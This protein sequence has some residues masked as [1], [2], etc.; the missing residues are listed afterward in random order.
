MNAPVLRVVILAAGQGKRMQSTRPKV[1]HRLAGQPLLAYVLANAAALQA[2]HIQIVHGHA[3]E[4]VR[5][6]FAD[7]AVD[8]VQ[9]Q[10]PRGT[11]DAVRLALAAPV[12]S[13]EEVTLILYGDVPLLQPGTLQKLVDEARNGAIGLLTQTRETP[14]GYGRIV[15]N[16]QGSVLGIVEHKDASTEQRA[17]REI[18][19][20]ILAASS[21]RLRQWV[22]ALDSNNAQGEFYLT[23]IVGLAVRDGVPVHTHLPQH[24][25]EADGIND[26]A[27]LAAL[28]RCYQRF[29]ADAL[30]AKGTRLADP[31]RVDVRG[32]LLCEADVEID[33]GC[34]FEGEV[35]L[36]AG[37]VVE[38]YCVLRNT[39]V[40]AGSHIRAFSHLDGA[41][42]ADRCVIGPY[43][44]LRP[45]AELDDE[46]HIGNF[47]E[48]KASHI[49]PRSKANHL[50]YVGDASVGSGVNIGAGT[51]T[52]NFDGANKHRTV[53]GD[54]AF[55]GSASQLVAP[56]TVGAGATIG[57]GTTLVS[58]AP[59]DQLT[60]A[61]A[62]QRVISRWKRPQ[63]KP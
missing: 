1:L 9:Q 52:C 42:I 47:V 55:I 37:V 62:P 4:Q 27:Q 24:P 30:L 14:D 10:P 41:R 39:H 7:A 53:I 11:G 22:H 6:A 48:V 28:E 51:I 60:L 57:A 32:T 46:V 49:G 38:A 54:G 15:R 21:T 50:S 17:I 58:D 12:A 29:L 16:A 33:V 18:N 63:K 56:V 43:A 26:G 13:D 8:W 44:R 20:G 36:G 45:G 19:T 2:D 3:G 5:A 31:A 25:W 23:D 40:G 61:R 35:S 34:V 59:A